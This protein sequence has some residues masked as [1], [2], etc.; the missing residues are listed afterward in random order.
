MYE[1][2]KSQL[3]HLCNGLMEDR[4]ITEVDRFTG[5][6]AAMGNE[7][8]FTSGLG[9]VVRDSELCAAKL[10]L[11]RPRKNAARISKVVADKDE[12]TEAEI[13]D[14]PSFIQPKVLDTHNIA[15]IRRDFL[16]K[17]SKSRSDPRTFSVQQ[18]DKYRQD[19]R[20]Q[21]IQQWVLKHNLSATNKQHEPD[22]F[23]KP[24]DG[25]MLGVELSSTNSLYKDPSMDLVKVDKKQVRFVSN[26]AI[27]SPS[28]IL[29]PPK[30]V[31]IKR[32]ELGD[33]KDAADE[34]FPHQPPS[35]LCEQLKSAAFV[36]GLNPRDTGDGNE[37]TLRQ[38]L[39]RPGRIVDHFECIHIFKQ[40]LEF[41]DLAHA[42]G[43][44]LRNVRP[45][46]FV[47]SSLHRVSFLEPGSSRSCSGSSDPS[48]GTA[49]IQASL[50]DTENLSNDIT[51]QSEGTAVLS[52]SLAPQNLG[53]QWAEEQPHADGRRNRMGLKEMS[54]LSRRTEAF[55]ETTHAGFGFEARPSGNSATQEISTLGSLQLSLG[56]KFQQDDRFPTWTTRLTEE[57]WYASPEEI[58][59]G[60][61]SYASD[62][63][64]LGVLFFELFCPFSCWEEY[65]RLM[66]D[67]RH[68]ILPSHMLSDWPKEAA[69]CL[70]LLHPEPNLR[71]KTREMLQLDILNE[72]GE[73]LT[74]K[75]VAVSIEEKEAEIELL[76][77]FLLRVQQQKKDL[78]S[79]LLKEISYLTSDI[80]E[81]K[82]RRSIFQVTGIQNAPLKEQSM[83]SKIT[84]NR[85]SASELM[86]EDLLPRRLDTL[87]KESG[88]STGQW[89][90]ADIAVKTK[91]REM[92]WGI[93]SLKKQEELQ[94]KR[95][96]LMSNF[97]RLEEVYF[98]LRSKVP[99]QIFHSS[100]TF[101]S[102][103]HE[104]SS[105]SA[106]TSALDA[107]LGTQHVSA[108]GNVGTK[109]KDSLG[110]F[111]DSLCKYARYRR[112][113]VKAT[114]QHG[115]FLNAANM[116]CSLSFD[117]DQEY[118]ATAGIC[119]RIRVFECDAVL[120]ENVDIHFPVVEMISRSKLSSICWNSYIKSH[121]A[122]S[123]YDGVVQL[124]DASTGQAL[125]RYDEHQKR[126]WSVDFSQ[127]DPTKLTSG[128]D[129]GC[130]KIWSIN[131]E[132][133]IATIKT[134]AN[135]C[136]VQFR[137]DSAHLIAFGS[138]DYKVYCYDLRNTRFP[139]CT[140]VNHSKAVSYV[141]FLDAS[142]L[143]SAS[144]DNTLKLWDL[145]QTSSAGEVCRSC[146]LTYTGHTN[147]KNFV[148]LSVMD[149]YIA[150]GSETNSVFVYHKS[151]PMPMLSHKFGCID[152]ISGQDTGD[153][154][155]EFV[156]SVCWRGKSQLLVAANSMGNIKVLE[157]V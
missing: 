87:E 50:L 18:A 51:P 121:I 71:P 115:D 97:D 101:D 66:S 129:D 81:V 145:S 16:D 54:L 90:N 63:Y 2:C 32:G 123:D 45:S 31:L 17:N 73:A 99:P 130:V 85:D 42:Q 27:T 61:Y 34:A 135:V 107:N 23:R 30:S 14:R 119:K 102:L 55:T 138:A 77:D 134:K 59:D 86:S 89:M 132:G 96:R 22:S 114:L 68:R 11:E 106:T 144:T 111:F 126:A 46:A 19:F 157:M 88:E 118:F 82:R 65:L 92:K 41:V 52:T 95:A 9:Q 100:T 76:L 70:W 137:L 113:D 143:V 125:M 58:Q 103:K 28:G 67:L 35:A 120:S 151:L 147:E 142:T 36:G 57:I 74:E 122:S 139:W 40:I 94:S 128:S 155:G 39:I 13:G 79:R 136:C 156:S 154:N 127:S 69:F 25:K 3:S 21:Q 148:G 4:G 47:L 153:G 98:S 152:S 43:V 133:S 116:V 37:K 80:Q 110:C 83:P 141:K 33:P 64:S 24:G 104:A 109:E 84:E 7:Q 124:W 108:I 72:G 38:W 48:T 6:E 105:A 29:H 150:C 1:E 26:G 131:Q 112:F 12:S 15:S 20:Q 8:I 146:T 78:V 117:R 60:M 93:N 10:S 49:S 75:Q 53:L 5:S 149:G 91:E 140:L 62:I 56:N 44:V